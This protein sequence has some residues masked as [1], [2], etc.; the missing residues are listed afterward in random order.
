MMFIVFNS[1]PYLLIVKKMY[2]TVHG[3]PF[4]NSLP[5][6]TTDPFQILPS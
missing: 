2:N 3:I 6:K 5:F 4:N 1:L